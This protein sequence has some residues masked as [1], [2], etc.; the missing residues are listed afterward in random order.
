MPN[1]NNNAPETVDLDAPIPF[2]TEGLPEHLEVVKA[3]QPGWDGDEPLAPKEAVTLPEFELGRDDV[4]IPLPTLDHLRLA[5]VQLLGQA[6]RE[7]LLVTPDLESPRFNNEEFLSALSAFVRTSRHTVTRILVGNP[8]DAVREGH[9]LISMI[10]RLSSRIE[11]RQLSA[12]DF[13]PEVS[14]MLADHWAVLRCTDRSPWQGGLTPKDAAHGR[15]YR[16]LFQSWWERG[17]VIADFRN[18]KI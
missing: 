4:L 18:L 3:P 11:I 12:D 7:V 2:T 10:H 9:K 15:R 1:D 5:A 17:S 6:Q 14:W 8:D 13:D 16:D